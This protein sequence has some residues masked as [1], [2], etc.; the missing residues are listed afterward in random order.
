MDRLRDFLEVYLFNFWFWKLDKFDCIWNYYFRIKRFYL[1]DEWE[2]LLENI[3]KWGRNIF[4]WCWFGFGRVY[5]LKIVR[6]I[7]RIDK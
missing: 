1:V 4:R 3:R 7:V 2:C 5:L 6:C